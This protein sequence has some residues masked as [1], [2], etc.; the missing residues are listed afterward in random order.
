MHY[1]INIISVVAITA[2]IISAAAV[3][4]DIVEHFERENEPT[5]TD[6]PA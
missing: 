2:T 6:V 4:V 3:S 5:V 1:V